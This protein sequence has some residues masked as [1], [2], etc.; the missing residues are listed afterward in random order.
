MEVKELT[1]K[2]EPTRARYTFNLGNRA[3]HAKLDHK[4][5]LICGT[6]KF[7]GIIPFK[8]MDH[9]A[10]PYIH[11]RSKNTGEPTGQFAKYFREIT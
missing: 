10:G 1:A 9:L 2:W 3:F 5:T 11:I 8:A 7:Q 6:R 4:I